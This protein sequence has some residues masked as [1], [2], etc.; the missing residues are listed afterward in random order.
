MEGEGARVLWLIET[1]NIR[2]V[3][4]TIANVYPELFTLCLALSAEY[5]SIEYG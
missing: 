4:K 3:Y 1:L 5:G 2:Y